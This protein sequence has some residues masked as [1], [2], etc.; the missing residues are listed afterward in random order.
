MN[1][2]SRLFQLS[3][4]SSLD[5]DFC[6]SR[7]HLNFDIILWVL[8]RFQ[9]NFFK[10][11]SLIYLGLYFLSTTMFQLKKIL[12]KLLCLKNHRN[13]NLFWYLWC[14]RLTADQEI[15]SQLKWNEREKILFK[16]II[17]FQ[18]YKTRNHKNEVSNRI[19]L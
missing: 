14:R 2:Q 18:N 7:Y 19:Y 9:I 13:L 6:E 10:N 8:L 16:I 1:G 12:E 15:E 11:S 4:I 3:N 17:L 5:N